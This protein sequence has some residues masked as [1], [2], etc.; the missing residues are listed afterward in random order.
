MWF[1]WN[2]IE[3]FNAWHDALKIELGYPL[4]STNQATGLPDPDAQITDSYT[5][6]IEIDGIIIAVVESEY[7]EGLT[8]TNLRRALPE[9]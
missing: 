2:S 3:E 6:P 5:A 9:L 4:I 1:E 8:K 7:A